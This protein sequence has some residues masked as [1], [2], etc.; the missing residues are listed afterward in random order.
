ME[1]MAWEEV[2]T[3]K[4]KGGLGIRDPLIMG[5]YLTTKTWWRWIKGQSKLWEKVWKAKYV[6]NIP[7]EGLIHMHGEI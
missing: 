6:T 1:L 5:K 2:C 3:P 7:K 4:T